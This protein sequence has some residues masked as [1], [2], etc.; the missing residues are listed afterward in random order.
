MRENLPDQAKINR[1]PQA[2]QRRR[3]VTKARITIRLDEEVI[4]Q[5]KQMV[6]EGQGYQSLIN[7]A[8]REWLA[9]QGVKEL[10]GKELPAII[11]K[12]VS[13]LQAKKQPSK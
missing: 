10:I 2:R 11:E 7:Q 8:L 1:G 9:A 3:E 4:E 5:F 12:A 6:P 13:S